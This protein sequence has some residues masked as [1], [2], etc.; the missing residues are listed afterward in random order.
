MRRCGS[1]SRA[2]PTSC[3]WRGA[4]AQSVSGARRARMPEVPLGDL[5]FPEPDRARAVTLFRST[6]GSEGATYKPLYRVEL[7][8]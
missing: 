1:A 3:A 4:C 2:T 7:D 5:A 6:L 8:G